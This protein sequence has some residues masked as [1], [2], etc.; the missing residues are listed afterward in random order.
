MTAKK[1]Y[2]NQRGAV[3]SF[4]AT[5]DGG[6]LVKDVPV[7]VAG[8]WTDMHGI[9]T[10]FSEE[11]LQRCAAQWNDNGVWTRH[12]GGAPR[13]VATDKVGSVKNP[14]YSPERSAVIGDV[15]FHNQTD[16]SRASSALVQM[17]KEDGGIKD[18]SAETMVE[19]DRD[20]NVL[21]VTFTGLALVEDGACELC[22]LPAFGKEDTDMADEIREKTTEEVVKDTEDKVEE[23][24]ETGTEEPKADE[25]VDILE[26]FVEAL[27]PESGD[28]IR[29][30]VEAEGEDRT[31]A[32]GRLEGCLSAWGVPCVADEY[33][34]LLDDKLAEFSK[35]FSDKLTDMETKIAQFS[36]PQG[37]KGHA[38][39]DRE[40]QSERQ[41]VTFYGNGRTALY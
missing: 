39:A 8:T 32:L 6:L 31:R 14:R 38:G 19:I 7:M 17:A 40:A 29:A 4:E 20:G 28:Y 26:K 21:D 15:Y 30:V 5:E 11:V 25:L 9:T 35:Q 2:Y 1:C 23:K 24:T 33:G 10:T 12:A 34:K 16:A 37:I 3:S 36:A 41:T 27:V 13:N 18:V 22:K